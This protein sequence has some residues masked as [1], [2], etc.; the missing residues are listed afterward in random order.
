L[1]TTC[2]S[3]ELAIRTLAGVLLLMTSPSP[4]EDVAH[5]APLEFIFGRVH[6]RF[7]GFGATLARYLEIC[8]R[9]MV[10]RP[11]GVDQDTRVSIFGRLS[12]TGSREPS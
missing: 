1:R 6:I 8:K 2:G 9:L 4:L 5:R 3:E 10:D 11:V 12:S 7:C